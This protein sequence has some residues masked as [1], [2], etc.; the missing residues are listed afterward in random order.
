MNIYKRLQLKS[1]DPEAYKSWKFLK[2]LKS[3]QHPNL[4]FPEKSDYHFKH[5]GNAGDVIYAFPAMRA[6][7]KKA[8]IHLHLQINQKGIYGKN[9]HPLGD[10]M[11][12]EKMV[13]ML[14]P[15]IL[16][17]PKFISVDI[18]EGQF[19][20]VDLD[21]F[22]KY[23]IW[24]NRGNIAH[25]YFLTFAV[26]YPLHNPWLIAEADTSLKNAIVIARSQRYHAPGIDYTFL[27]RYP[28]IYFIGVTAEF[29]EMK[30]M[31]PGVKYLPVQDFLQMASYIAGCRLFIGNQ[32][33]PFSI[34]EALK[35]NRLLEWY[36]QS[37]NVSVEG[38]KGFEFCFQ[39]QFEKLTIDRFE[40]LKL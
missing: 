1:N 34:A 2:L 19:I 20:D 12:T 29:N 16:Y 7:A 9:I 3:V 15:L 39:P 23:P 5:S 40:S 6:I 37:P 11:L 28:E 36:F 17:Q 13:K 4:E 33:F 10:K 32:S 8:N 22:R 38:E 35:V 27:K 25:W 31:V 18:F 24:L 14:E 26:N 21:T 30:Q